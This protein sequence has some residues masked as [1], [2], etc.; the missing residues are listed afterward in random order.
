MNKKKLSRSLLSIALFGGIATANA[1][2]YSVKELGQFED[3]RQHFSLD[4]NNNGDVVGIVRDS[5]NFPFYLADYLTKDPSDLKTI[6]AVSD[7]ELASQQFD[8]STA[9]CLKFELMRVTRSSFSNSFL[10]GLDAEF[11][12]IGDSKPFIEMGSSKEVV[13]LTDEVDAELGDFTRSTVEQ[14][15]AIND[16]GIAVGSASAPFFPTEFTP[17]E[18]GEEL[19]VET[20]FIREFNSRA[21][22]Y[23]DG[24]VTI[25]EPTE[26]THGGESTATDISNT[27]FISGYE[28]VAVPSVSLASFDR[29]CKGESEPVEVCIWSKSRLGTFYEINAAVWQIDAN[30][31]VVSKTSYPIAFEPD[32]GDNSVYR[33]VATGINDAGIAVGYG[34]MPDSKLRQPYFFP[35][36]YRDGVSTD[37]LGEHGDYVGGFA[38]DISNE[39]LIVGKMLTLSQGD[40]LDQFFVYDLNEGTMESPETF[41]KT[42]KSVANGVNDAGIVVGEAEYETTQTTSR[43]KH[44]FIYDANT[45]VFKDVNDHI[46]CASDY[47]IV[48]M[49]SINNQNQIVA[50]ALKKVSKKDALGEVILDSNG[51]PEIEEVAVAVLLEKTSDEDP[52]EC[53]EE[54]EKKYERKGFTNGLLTSLLLS[55]FIAIRR[56][57]L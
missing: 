29:D 16:A 56:R 22:I 40:T 11:Q 47:E 8:A 49:R 25:L 23:K 35:M 38:L 21:T 51:D 43:R 17:V 52:G 3:Y 41:F 54:V 55:G 2:T 15:N 36:V 50:T 10:Y 37:L 33:T 44:G 53:V 48:E 7:T 5:F 42:S 1:E 26:T 19:A 45:K 31:N 24:V 4:L 57:F 20:Q 46:A 12:K 32:S 39:N 14:L 13:N 27:G 34:H 9:L 28:S 30:A 6:C 18:D